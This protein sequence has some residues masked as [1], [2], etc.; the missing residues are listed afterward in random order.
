M[1][2]ASRHAR[3]KILV[4][5]ASLCLAA[6]PAWGFAANRLEALSKLEKGRWQIR[7]LDAGVDRPAFC[8]VD[9]MAL[10]QIE[11]DGAACASEVIDSGPDGGTIHYTCRGHGFGHSTIRIATPRF[12]RIDTQGIK[13]NQPF[14]YRAEARKVGDC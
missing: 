13:D 1:S 7:D 2:A 4:A 10:V 11:H 5:G 12:A 14:S 8:L 3:W 6:M 9:P